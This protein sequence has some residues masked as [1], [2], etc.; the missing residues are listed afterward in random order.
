MTGILLGLALAQRPAPIDPRHQTA[1]P[2]GR[3]SQWAQPWRAY[4]ETPSAAAFVDGIGINFGVPDGAN[5]DLLATMLARHG[6]RHAR[7]EI[8]W[9]NLDWDDRMGEHPD[10]KARL[11]ALQRHGMRPLILLNAHHGVPCPL[12]FFERTVVEDAPAG[13][14]TVRLDDASGLVLGR[15]GLCD[16]TD[17]KAAEAIVTAVDGDRATLSKPL[18]KALAKGTR[19]RMATLKYRP[20]SVPGSPEDRETLEGWR[21]YVRE[22]VA[23]TKAILGPGGFDLEIW[24]ELSF[25]SD[26]LYVD[27]YY[28]PKPYA[29]REDDVWRDVVRATGDVAGDL[30]GVRLVDGFPN[31]VPWPASSTEPP[32]VTGLSHHPYAGRKTYPRDAG[33]EGVDA[34]F[35]EET[36][37]FR[38][39][40]SALFPEYFGAALQTETSIRDASPITTDIYGTKHGRLAREGAPCPLWI[41]EVGIAPQE[42]GVK[43]RDE[44]LR[45][46]AKTTARSYVFWLG[47]G[48]ERLYLY[49]TSA[50][51]LDLGLLS[52]AFLAYAKGAKP[53]P[54]DDAPLVSPA[55]RVVGR[56]A[57]RMTERL[58][59]RA[60]IAP[61]SLVRAEIPG[62]HVQFRGDGTPAHPDLRDEDVL[63][64]QPFAVNARRYVV[65]VYVMSRDVRQDLAPEDATIQL[66]GAALSAARAY[67]PTTDRAVPVKVVARGKGSITVRMPVTDALR[68]LILER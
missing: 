44:A 45:L 67:D 50:G 3:S 33:K 26:F 21:K 58:D 37:G 65:P 49:N 32:E 23:W 36:G 41:T 46:K 53:Y 1:V 62:D 47:K 35:R 16:L 8:S 7:V 22:V 17:Y 4:L 19:V 51:D 30:P 11:V 13:A 54:K 28:D 64:V 63:F 55:L 56:M 57:A 6:F 2:F 68:L 10:L 27:R 40:Y 43:D 42:D 66:A 38:P 25:G 31:T 9:G 60:K 59:R 5:P 12:R 48:V 34:L 15:S 61:L 14:R 20:F 29:Y 52:D 39:T 18:P 24:N